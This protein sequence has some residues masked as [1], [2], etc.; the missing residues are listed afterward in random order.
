MSGII[1][2]ARALKVVNKGGGWKSKTVKEE[3]DVEVGDGPIKRKEKRI[4][5]YRKETKEKGTDYVVFN[6][7]ACGARNKKNLYEHRYMTNGGAVL[8][9]CS[10]CFREIEVSRP[11]K[12]IVSPG[13][14]NLEQQAKQTAKEDNGQHVNISHF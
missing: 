2:Q 8:F 3:E 10:H 1:L 11:Q 12:T 14:Y 7:P 9:R 5:Q 6:C 13:E 4:K